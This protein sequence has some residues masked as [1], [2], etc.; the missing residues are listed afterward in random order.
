MHSTW[1]WNSFIKKEDKLN[2]TEILL[3]L[4]SKAC[5]EARVVKAAESRAFKDHKIM[6][7]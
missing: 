1:I 7:T 3:V 4:V 6:K 5:S 2:I